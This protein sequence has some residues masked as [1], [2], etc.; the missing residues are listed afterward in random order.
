LKVATAYLA[1]ARFIRNQSIN[2]TPYGVVQKVADDSTPTAERN[3][4]AAAAD[5]E[6]IGKAYLMATMRYWKK[7]QRVCCENTRPRTYYTAIGN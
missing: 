4:A 3:I 2:V 7:I 6:R 1:Y 5:A